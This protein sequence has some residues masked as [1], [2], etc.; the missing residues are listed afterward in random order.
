MQH[1]TDQ[2]QIPHVMTSIGTYVYVDSFCFFAPNHHQCVFKAKRLSNS[3][4]FIL[5]VWDLLEAKYP[6]SFRSHY[7]SCETYRKIREASRIESY[8]LIPRFFRDKREKDQHRRSNIQRDDDDDA[9]SQAP[10]GS[11]GG[12]A[13]V[14]RGFKSVEEFSYYVR[15]HQFISSIKLEVK[16]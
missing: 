11:N 14:P 16:L 15:F 3:K 5:V 9:T 2:F 10:Q 1:L 7:K 12:D 4:S 8:K 6:E 13:L